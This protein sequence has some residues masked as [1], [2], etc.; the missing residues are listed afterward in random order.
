LVQHPLTEE[1]R[2]Q[3]MRRVEHARDLRRNRITVWERCVKSYLGKTLDKMPDHDTVVVPKDM[4][5]LETKRSQLAFQ[6]PEVQLKPLLPGLEQATL[7]FQAALNHE[8]GPH[9]ADLL[10]TVDECLFNV[11]AMGIAPSKIGYEASMG[12][13]EVEEPVTDPLTGQPSGEPQK[14]KVPFLAKERYFWDTVDPRDFLVPYEFAGANFDRAP[15]LGCEYTRDFEVAKK[16]YKLPSDFAAFGTDDDRPSLS[17]EKDGADRD[18]VKRK[19]RVVEIWYYAS[20]FDPEEQHPD[21]LRILVLVQGHD[22]AIRHQ[23]SPY[24]YIDATGKLAGMLGHSLHVMTLR[25]V[26]D[27]AYPPSEIEMSLGLNEEL[28]KGR[29]QMVA[30]RDTSIPMRGIDKSRVSPDDLAKI[31]AGKWQGIIPM[32]GDPRNIMAEIARAQFPRENFTFNEIIDRDIE[33]VWA[34]GKP[35][36]GLTEDSTKTATELQLAQGAA[37]VRLDKERARVLKWFTDGAT[38]YGTLLQQFKD[39]AS[40]VEV[41]GPQ[42]AQQLMAWD[43]TKIQGKFL[44]KAKPDSALRMDAQAERQQLLNL[45]NL[46]GKDPN[47]ARVEL[48]KSLFQKFNMDPSRIVVEKLPEPGPEK[49]KLALSFNGEDALNE[50]AML[51]AQ[52]NGIAVPPQLIQLA[53]AAGMVRSLSQQGEVD[54]SNAPLAPQPHGGAAEQAEPIG[55]HA[56]RTS[57]NGP[58]GQTMRPGTTP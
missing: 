34:L 23:D 13:R 48:L 53:Q 49:P 29:T 43:K 5:F 2:Q 32:D 47:V 37:S 38:K 7:M 27:R 46:T 36:R 40:Y 45:Y 9:G 18:V 25:N 51:L 35:Q 56:M 24:Q 55:K 30:Q 16:L 1:Q 3:W 20:Q 41:L 54:G 6:V 10:T 44:Y 42:G 58:L 4:P 15:W 22:K 33:E 14:R 57:G 17:D 11:I 21:R 19:V 28:S 12:E 26:A 31:L 50:A 52:A 8:L 39:D